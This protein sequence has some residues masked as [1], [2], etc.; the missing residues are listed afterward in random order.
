MFDL[1]IV[2][3]MVHD[4]SGGEPYAADV[5][6]TGGTIAAIGHDL[7]P[8]SREI[9]ASGCIVTPGFVD[10][11]T[12]YDAQVTWDPHLAPS[13][14]HGSTTVVMGNC[15][16]GIAPCKAD[17]RKML[18]EVMAGVEDIPEP[19][20]DHGI[21]WAWETFPE[22]LDVLETRHCDADFAAMLPHG[23]LR[24]YVMGKRGAE[25][26]PATDL[27]LAQMARL[28]REAMDAG[29]IGFSTSRTLVHRSVTGALAPAETASE[30]ELMTIARAMRDGPPSVLEYI[31]DFPGLPTGNT[32]DFDLMKR[33]AREADRPLSYTLTE[34]P[35]YPGSWQTLLKMTE[36]ANAE[37]LKVIGQVAPR[38]V[39]IAFGLDLSYNPFSFRP[40]YQAIAELPL[41]ERVAR[42]RDPAVRAAILGEKDGDGHPFVMMLSVRTD[43]MFRLGN[44][45]S[46][47]PAPEERFDRRA[48]A[49][50]V[51][52][53]EV[54]YDELID[55]DGHAI[56]YLPITNYRLGNLDS[57]LAMMRHPNTVVSLGDGGAHYG[58][59]CD[60]SYPTFA[61]TH[62]TRDRQGQKVPLP[63]M[64]RALTRVPALAVR[65]EDRGLLAVGYKADVNVI[66]MER[67]ELH[68]PEVRYDLPSGA[69]RI[70]QQATGYRATIVSG[71]VTRRDDQP[72]GELPGRLIR[73][74]RSDPA[75]QVTARQKTGAAA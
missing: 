49:R 47:E 40:G 73:G 9:D 25:R 6:I 32:A 7:G 24:V 30:E 33:F 74:T 18:V 20:M 38:A 21:P 14:D 52:V 53:E 26:E 70:A 67:L 10:I 54:V 16:V 12:H 75:T 15:A 31:A 56:L 8:A 2:G 62:W 39:G 36:Q 45:P 11:H 23:P 5:A 35:A 63:E 19:V 1:K 29:A 44:P 66:D 55:D 42:M 4:G 43:S 69:R 61:L 17:Q 34:S 57:T 27:D 41:A 64:V 72:T 3:G 28:T 59:I 46:Y 13:T 51:S 37:G 50:G 60:A 22:Y 58:M 65:L 71:V 68:F 48:A